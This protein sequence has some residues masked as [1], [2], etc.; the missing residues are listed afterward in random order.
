[1]TR[2]QM[3]V[4][5]FKSDFDELV[6]IGA[7][8]DGGV[9]RPALGHNH[10][11]ARQWFVER[12]QRDGLKVLVDSAKSLRC[13]GVCGRKEDPHIGF[14]FGQCTIWREI[15]RRLG[16]GCGIGGAERDQGVGQEPRSQ[17]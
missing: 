16:S 10:L 13:A 11:R 4:S 12:A 9:H 15:R 7:T 8:S 14:A 6:T 1:M 3:D 5:R 17:S 2:I